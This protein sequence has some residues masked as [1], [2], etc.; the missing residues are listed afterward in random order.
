MK[1]VAY[2]NPF[3]PPE[4][5]AAHGLAPHWLQPG[6]QHHG[7]ALATL[8]GGCPFAGAYGSAASVEPDVAAILFATPCDPMRFAAAIVDRRIDRP[9]FLFNMPSTEHAAAASLYRTELERLGRFLESIGGVAPTALMLREVMLRFDAARSA[10][11]RA[12]GR[13][14]GRAR[15]EAILRLRNG[16]TDIEPLADQV[17]P[18]GVALALLGGPL[19]AKDY[20]LFDLIER[21]GGYVAVDGSEGGMRTLPGAFDRHRLSRDPALELARA[22]FQTIPDV[23]RRP[24]RK[25]FGWLDRM[26][27]ETPIRGVLLRRYVWCDLW[28]AELPRLREH[29]GLPTLEIDVNHDDHGV[30][31]RI[32]GRVEAFLESL[33]Q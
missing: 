6:R 16:I 21:L 13:M 15:A 25:L 7:A 9:S 27:K 20:E 4:W 31:P 19:V 11:R 10:L 28:H 22:Y 5:I 12:E 33:A 23:F 30:P 14:T 8:R 24:N 29:C 3:I 1:S 26:K 17:A 18:A 2:A 32:A